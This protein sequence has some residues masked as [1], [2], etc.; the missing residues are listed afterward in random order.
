MRFPEVVILIIC[1][2]IIPLGAIFYIDY[3]NKQEY[4][5]QS[6]PILNNI[7]E[8]FKEFYNK[9]RDWKEP[10]TKL[11]EIDM[12]KDISYYRGDKSYTINKE[13]VYICLKDDN[14]N[15]YDE[16]MLI[17]VIAHEMAHCI[18]DEI[19]H[20]DKFHYIFE[21]LLK[22]LTQEGYYNPSIPVIRNYCEHGD[23]EV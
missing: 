2:F 4:F 23:H 1:I 8:K 5:L 19:G 22:L 11:N 7:L 6:D 3:K 21:E 18:C 12:M 16:N 20:T 10:L 15:Y 9:D 13:K 14:G 17:Y